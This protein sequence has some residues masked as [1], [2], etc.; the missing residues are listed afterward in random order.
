MLIIC[1]ISINDSFGQDKMIVDK[2][3]NVNTSYS[4]FSEH[5]DSLSDLPAVIQFNLKG[6]IERILGS[7]SDS[8]SFSHGQ[9]YER[10]AG[11]NSRSGV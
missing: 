10:I 1:L 9:I 6:Y 11:V 7:M 2:P 3:F 4:M 8:I 5:I